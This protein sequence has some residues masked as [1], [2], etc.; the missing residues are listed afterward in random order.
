MLFRFEAAYLADQFKD[1]ESSIRWR[2]AADDM[3]AKRTTYWDNN[4][5]YFVKGFTDS[6]KPES[7]DRTIDSSSLFGVFMFGYYDINDTK[8]TEAY[9][10]LKQKLMTDGAK[11][12][13][14]ENDAYRRNGD[15][16][17][18]P[19]PVTSLW[20]AQYALE[21]GDKAQADRVLDWVQGSMFASGVIAEQYS[22]NNKPLSVAPLAWSQAEYMNVLLDMITA[23]GDNT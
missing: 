7:F 15:D 1:D 3:L 12:I 23:P 19:W 17:S 5:Q 11:V 21:K 9:D 18:N 22:A 10:M 6:K 8:V 14:Y 20:A 4:L 16:P 13:R 2:E